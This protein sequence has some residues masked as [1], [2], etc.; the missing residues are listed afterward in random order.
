MLDGLRAAKLADKQMLNMAL[1][2]IRVE[3]AG[4]VPIPEGQSAGNTVNSP[5]DR[6]EPGSGVPH[7]VS[8]NLGNTQPG[9]GA[10]FKGRGYVQVTG[11]D[12]YKRIGDQIGADLVGNP[13]LANDPATA[14]RILAQFLKN[15]ET[16]IRAALGSNDLTDARIAVNGGTHGLPEFIAAYNIGVHVLPASGV[17][18]RAFR[19][20]FGRFSKSRIREPYLK[21]VL[22]LIG[23][24]VLIVRTPAERRHAHTC[25]SDAVAQAKK[26][27][28]FYRRPDELGFAGRWSVDRAATKIG[29]VP[30]I[31]GRRRYD[32]LQ[33][34]GYI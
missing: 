7:N 31:H 15:K 1:S 29:T 9:D 32:V 23:L 14:G 19:F 6:Y 27:L 21:A 17:K 16:T 25:S 28:A 20:V 5:F 3:T 30:A 22:A 18:R 34:W 2:T 10:R 4:F 11:R 8:H 33:V 13:E 24:A 12:N 26:L